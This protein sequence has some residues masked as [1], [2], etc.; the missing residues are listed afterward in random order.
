MTTLPDL[1]AVA[2]G[3]QP[4]DLVIRGGRI[5]N[6]FSGDYEA[7]DIAIYQGRIAGIGH[8]PNAATV[9]D[10]AGATI[11]PGLIDAHV[12]I[13]SSLC[14]PAQFAAAILPRGVTTAVIDPHEIAN[15]AGIVGIQYMIESCRRLPLNA[16]VMASSCVPATNMASSG[17]TLSAGDLSQL[18]RAGAV[19]G[20][21]EVMNYPGVIHADPDMLAKLVAF[22]GRPVDGHAPN[23]RGRALNAYAAAGI[24]S[25]HECTSVE[26]A[27]EKLAR[28]LY[29][30]IREATNARNLSSLLPL[31][32]PRNS[33]R[34]AFCTDDRIPHD[35]LESGSIDHMLRT[36]IAA[37][38]DPFDALCMATL[39]PAEWFG[40]AHLGAIAPGRQAD[41]VLVDDLT[42]FNVQQVY[43]QGKLIARDGAMLPTIP[44]PML[45]TASVHAAV[46]I[47]WNSV[48]F[49]IA[50]RGDSANVIGLHEDQLVTDAR[51]LPLRKHNGQIVA[52]P[53]RD[54]L[55]L[56]V[57]ERH[58]SRGR[59]GLGLIQG[60]GLKR[61][62]LAGTVAH[63]HHNLIVVGAD[64][65]SMWTAGRAVAD[66][67]GGLVVANG[68]AVLA[69]LPLP[70]A[71][72]M[73][74]QPIEAVRNAY[75][76]LRQAA[77][78]LGSPLHDPF[79]AMSFMGLEVIPRLKLTDQGL[80]DVTAFDFIGLFDPLLT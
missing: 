72:L 44:L 19:H 56:A 16:V 21:A 14:A 13:E 39:N 30:L 12:H 27:A 49:T 75:D 11:T 24:G 45:D 48:D 15:V 9:I 79:M 46:H 28:G 18:R 55:K 50:N 34:F 51:R 43:A 36:A 35:L 3:D 59:M 71:G 20:L 78:A 68:D 70:I 22:R 7:G 31:I 77:A 63:D 65:A 8:Y 80:V 25:D 32:T 57:I 29:I 47:D 40:L 60:F 52:D 67:G 54:I 62:A 26:E 73:S 58:H 38:I 2:R 53:E 6:V 37:G 64:D 74:D 4:A 23:V 10:A 17:A 42:S 5:A 1:L 33:R 61:G 41:L 69:A 76:A 66:M